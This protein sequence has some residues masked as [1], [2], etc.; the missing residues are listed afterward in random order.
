MW[1]YGTSREVLSIE[2]SKQH[3]PA[4]KRKY[5]DSRQYPEAKR[6]KVNRIDT[7]EQSSDDETTNVYGINPSDDVVTVKIGGVKIR[8]FIDSGSK[9]NMIDDKTWD[10]LKAQNAAYVMINGSK[11][12]FSGYGKTPLNL[13]AVFKSR[14]S[15]YERP[16]ACIGES[17]F[18]VI[19]GGQQLLL[20][21][22]SAKAL[23][24]LLTGTECLQEV[25]N[26]LK[27]EKV[28]LSL[29]LFLQIQ[30]S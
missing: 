21:N 2:T 30:G 14:I 25:K 19:Q 12:K 18:Y 20:G 24:V 29:S 10:Y 16:D 7:T 9:Y 22:I 26:V 11:K 8:M 6:R 15:L 28:S 1:I 13:I 17:D 3:F 5:S 27:S 23:G 4:V